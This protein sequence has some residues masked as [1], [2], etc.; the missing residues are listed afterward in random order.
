MHWTRQV[1]A[2][3]KQGE[4]QIYDLGQKTKLKSATMN[5]NVVFWKWFSDKSIGLVTDTTVYHWDAFDP[6]Q[7]APIEVFKRN[8]CL[9]GC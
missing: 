7:A 9:S 2:V 8:Q 5:E 6:T 3:K 4:L 1:I